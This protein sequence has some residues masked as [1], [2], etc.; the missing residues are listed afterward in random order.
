[1]SNLN[2]II[3][4][5]NLSSPG[6]EVGRM[7]LSLAKRHAAEV[8]FVTLFEHL[9]DF[10]NNNSFDMTT[11]AKFRRNEAELLERLHR[12]T[13]NL[14]AH[15]AL[16]TVLTGHPSED[17]SQLATHWG[18]DLIL[19][20]HGT[21]Q[22]IQNGWVPWLYSITPLPCKLYIVPQEPSHFLL[23]ITNLLRWPRP[24]AC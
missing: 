10:A 17:V 13:T 19:A 8:R 9:D 4:V 23:S 1:M 11:Q 20:D 16:C 14:G 3:A 5:I 6:E 18:A 22:T 24:K 2:R 7:A 15:G 12:F 21:A